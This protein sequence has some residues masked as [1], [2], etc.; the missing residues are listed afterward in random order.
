M[1]EHYYTKHIHT[2]ANITVYDIIND[3]NCQKAENNMTNFV[4]QT[5]SN[6][7]FHAA[8]EYLQSLMDLKWFTRCL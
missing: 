2:M 1:N 3:N 7:N 4:V 8:Y 5:I 6:L